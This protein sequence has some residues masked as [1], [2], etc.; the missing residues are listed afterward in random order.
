MTL[1]T[2]KITKPTVLVWAGCLFAS[3]L[4][5]GAAFYLRTGVIT[6][7]MPNGSNVVMWGFA[8]DSAFG[9]MDGVVTV[10]GPTLTI[11]PGDAT[12]TIH[13]DN[14]LPEPV[15]IVIPGQTIVPTPVRLP[16]GRVR[17]F[18]AETAPYNGVPVDYTWSNL[19]PG[20]FLYQSGTHPSVQVQMG[21][22]GAVRKDYAFG[23]TYPGVTFQSEAT[24]LYS[25]IDPALHEAVATGNYGPGQAMT[26]TVDYAPKYFLINGQAYTNGLAPVSAGRP[27]DTLVIHFL[28]AGLQTHVPIVNNSYFQLIAEDGFPYP[29]PKDQYSVFL[30]A[31][32]TIDALYTT[33]V[34]NQLAVYDR[35]L[36][37][38]NSTT[39]DGGM[40]T[41]LNVCHPGTPTNPPAWWLEQYYGAGPYPTNLLPVYIAGLDPTNPASIFVI[42]AI[43]GNVQQAKNVYF[44]PT[45][46]GRFYSMEHRT[47]LL[48]GSWSL[49]QTNIPGYAGWMFLDDVHTNDTGFY[50]IRVDLP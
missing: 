23:K 42:T 45:R 43:T 12:L 44:S 10:P 16:N 22:Y 38:I 33:S 29:Y 7:T 4:A 15:S 37:M 13:L 21:L 46:T 30:P 35:R 17:S 5:H 9:A 34:S 11:L 27:G 14:N 26:S 39:T 24:L 49:V 36:N 47:N 41:Y 48:T 6:N 18:T 40:L 25:E 19:R 20:T 3:T 1:Q 2:L 31:G 8:Q 32:K 28:N 50:R